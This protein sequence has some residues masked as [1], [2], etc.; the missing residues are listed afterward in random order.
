MRCCFIQHFL[1]ATKCFSDPL[2]FI[3]AKLIASACSLVVSALTATFLDSI[4]GMRYKTNLLLG[5]EFSDPSVSLR[6]FYSEHGDSLVRG[7]L[8]F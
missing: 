1:L 2:F 6:A 4:K 7:I 8:L 5:L 3:S